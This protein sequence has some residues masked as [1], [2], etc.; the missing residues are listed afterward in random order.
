M[1][2]LIKLIKE[3][4][5]L[6][7]LAV[8]FLLS[9][10]ILGYKYQTARKYIEPTIVTEELSRESTIDGFE[11]AADVVTYVFSALKKMIWIWG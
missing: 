1:R 6:L 9:L 3:Y 5:V 7:G 4:P 11:K 8:V 2:K 10:T